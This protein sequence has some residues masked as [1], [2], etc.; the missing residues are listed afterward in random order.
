MTDESTAHTPQER[1]LTDDELAQWYRST[2][3][4][5]PVIEP[6][7]LERM[8]RDAWRELV[9]SRTD[10]TLSCATLPY[11][12]VEILPA[13]QLITHLLRAVIVYTDR[14]GLQVQVSAEHDPDGW[15]SL[16]FSEHQHGL[17]LPDQA[18]A[19]DPFAWLGNPDDVEHG[20]DLPAAERIVNGFGG[21]LVI[22][23]TDHGS[24][25]IVMLPPSAVFDISGLAG[26]TQARVSG[27]SLTRRP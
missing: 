7:D 4:A 23:A 21:Q 14:F 17:P 12:V 22:S 16:R 20:T 13:M 15:V 8:L 18:T 11:L 2:R 19:L 6:V 25:V 10:A 24:E 1:N 26:V 27:G 3:P 9:G 5:S